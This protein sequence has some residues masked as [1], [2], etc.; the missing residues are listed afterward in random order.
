[1]PVVALETALYNKLV[2]TAALVTE[3]GGTY[4]YNKQAPQNPNDNYVVFSQQAGGDVN[5]TPIRERNILYTVMGIAL[6]QEKAGAID[7]DIDT[8]LHLAELTISGW[9]NLWLA[10]ETDINISQIDSGGVTRYHVGG[11]YRVVMDKTS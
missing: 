2:A 5:D 11:I 10:R 9:S 3:L 1:M 8:T 7:T 6:T 4:I